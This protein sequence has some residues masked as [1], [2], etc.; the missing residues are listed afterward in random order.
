MPTGTGTQ[1]CWLRKTA[2]A[3]CAAVLLALDVGSTLT[4][5]TAVWL[6]EDCFVIGA[7]ARYLRGSLG[8]GFSVR[9]ITSKGQHD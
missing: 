8:T 7:T 9:R 4:T 3:I 6:S 5:T 1:S 2:A